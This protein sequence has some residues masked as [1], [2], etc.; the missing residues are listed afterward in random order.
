ME[1]VVSTPAHQT[2]P[3]Q[4]Q[5]VPPGCVCPDFH[6]AIELIGKRW[7]G[8]IVSAL[9]ER[10]MRFGELRKAI[11]G[12]SDRLLS[13]RLRELE[14]EGLVQREVEAGTPV[15]VTYSLTEV[16]DGLGP[17]LGELKA[18]A[19]RWKCPDAA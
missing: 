8:A 1:P 10:P 7:T 13:Q 3:A 15:R 6:A 4:V 16:G 2:G 5:A 12:L 9:T 17:A 11:P 14:E 18:W 19:K